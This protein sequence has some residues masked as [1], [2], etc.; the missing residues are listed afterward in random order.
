[1]TRVVR[2]AALLCVAGILLA[3]AAVAGTP[4]PTTS[5]FSPY[6]D[7]GGSTAGS[8]DNCSDT[9]CQDYTMTIRDFA[10]TP[11]PNATVTVDL[12]GCPYFQIDQGA[13]Q[14]G[15]APFVATAL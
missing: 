14:I 13:N 9:F 15:R 6:I 4:D 7:V 8:P 1:M 10:S 12:S 11:V 5:T 3:S 2:I